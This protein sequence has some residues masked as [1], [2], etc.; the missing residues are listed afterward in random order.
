MARVAYV[1][2]YN[3]RIKITKSN[4]NWYSVGEEYEVRDADKYCCIGI[5]VW[6]NSAE[7]TGR[8]KS[9]D[10]VMNGHFKYI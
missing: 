8:V 9:P 5:Q 4:G 1:G 10:V 3:M 6:R 2:G 7:G